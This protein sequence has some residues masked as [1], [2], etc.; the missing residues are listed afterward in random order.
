VMDRGGSRLHTTGLRVTL[1]TLLAGAAGAGVGT[2]ADDRPAHRLD[3]GP[4]RVGL[5]SGVARLP[6]PVGWEPLNRRSS[7]PG[8]REATA[9][10]GAHSAV[11]LDIRPPE[12]PSLLPADVRVASAGNLP[13]P[14]LQRLD[15]RSVW[16]YE[17][18]AARTLVAMTL[19]TTGGVVT[20]ACQADARVIAAASDDCEGA[21]G[22][23]RIDGAAELMPAPET[24]ARIVLPAII[25]KLNRQRRSGRR[26]LRATRSPQRRG[27]A[28]QHLAL[29]YR[30]AAVRLRPLAAGEVRRLI[31][32]LGDLARDHRELAAASR[33]RDVHMAR[34]AGA[35]I[36]RRERR[37]APLLAAVSA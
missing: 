17:I 3:P 22:A 10:R 9:V 27:E 33:R 11:A 35:A 19:P 30:N 26:A 29:A 31:V 1:A 37:L 36:E 15:S 32:A 4:P 13:A 34:R 12:D 25:G 23:L 24:A 2:L 18:P 6:L 20:I 16:R 7:L 14:R 21:M 8:L 28:A 5:A